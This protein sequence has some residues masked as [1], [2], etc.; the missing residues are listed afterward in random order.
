MALKGN[1]A[2]FPICTLCASFSG[3][4]SWAG[5][6]R[7]QTTD[8]SP[9]QTLIGHSHKCLESIYIVFMEILI[10]T[11]HAR[12]AVLTSHLRACSSS[13]FLWVSPSVSFWQAQH[14]LLQSL[15][16]GNKNV[17]ATSAILV[18]LGIMRLCCHLKIDVNGF[19]FVLFHPN[20]NTTSGLYHGFS[21]LVTSQL[22]LIK[23][24]YLRIHRG[25]WAIKFVLSFDLQQFIDNK[26]RYTCSLVYAEW[27]CWHYL[28]EVCFSAILE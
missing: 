12:K 25:N 8:S 9:L 5:A 18:S 15:V 26:N 10:S 7:D 3:T 20:V 28:G 1:P 24:C 22:D 19:L 11:Q 23:V 27:S 13:N 16:E 6:Q 4:P 21:S 14:L 2:H 17:R